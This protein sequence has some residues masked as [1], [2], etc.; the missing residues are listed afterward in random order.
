MLGP[1]SANAT[2]ADF[3]DANGRRWISSGPAVFRALDVATTEVHDAAAREPAGPP[4]ESLSVS[5][6]AERLRPRRLVG[7]YE[8]RLAEPD[9]E[10]AERI[11]AMPKAA[12]V[13]GHQ[14]TEPIALGVE[15]GVLPQFVI[16][17]TDDRVP[18]WTTT[19]FPA[20]PFAYL[21][22]SCTATLIGRSTALCAA[23]CFYQNG[24]ISTP[25]ITFG[26]NTS[27]PTAP[28]G[29]YNADSLTLPGAWNNSEWDWDFAVLE[30]SPTRYPGNSTGWFGVEQNATGTNWIIGYPND[31][32]IPSPWISNGTYTAFPGSRYEHNIDIMPGESGACSYNANYRCT[33]L[34]STQWQTTSPAR[35]WNEV[36]RWDSTTYNF[37]DT[38]GN[39]P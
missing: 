7:G 31:K 3:I 33:G 25:G 34:Q 35:I 8:Y 10:L 14:P 28:Y 4:I 23:H 37:F 12:T 19:T 11:L 16:P 32:P 27:A 1:T 26:A 13:E 30:F 39:W 17:P 24:W 6:L 22:Q 15:T 9:F 20:R 2:G 38:Y 36:R 21:G 5:E 29:T 18:I